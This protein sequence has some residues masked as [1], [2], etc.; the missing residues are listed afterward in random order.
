MTPEGYEVPIVNINVDSLQTLDEL[1][2][3]Y[4]QEIIRELR[5]TTQ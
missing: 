2:V 1:F 5:E 3:L 4:Y